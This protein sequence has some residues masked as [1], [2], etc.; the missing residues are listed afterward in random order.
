MNRLGKKLKERL[1][2]RLMMLGCVLET[3]GIAGVAVSAFIVVMLI[4]FSSRYIGGWWIALMT[5]FMAAF[6]AAEYYLIRRKILIEQR[7]VMGDEV[8]F[9]QYPREYRREMRRKALESKKAQKRP[10]A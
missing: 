7:A 9:E 1:G 10:R 5:A 3:M 6:V 2:E 4:I 8:F